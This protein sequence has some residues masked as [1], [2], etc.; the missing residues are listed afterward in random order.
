VKPLKI[1]GMALLILTFE[2]Y[3]RL[4]GGKRLIINHQSKEAI[5]IPIKGGQ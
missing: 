2:I 4:R 3:F 5:E 1:I